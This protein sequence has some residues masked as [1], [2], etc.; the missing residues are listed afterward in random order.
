MAAESVLVVP[1]AV[2]TDLQIESG[3]VSDPAV[4]QAFLNATRTQ[5]SFMPREEAER[6]PD[7]VQPIPLAYIRHGRRLLV[8]PGD[9]RDPSDRLYRRWAVW[10]G[11]HIEQSDAEGGDP[12]QAGLR[13]ELVEEL[14]VVGLPPP[15]LVGL[16]GDAGS[17]RSRMHLGVVHRLQVDDPV[18]AAALERPEATGENG[19]ARTL[20]TDIDTLASSHVDMEPWS[21]F[22][23][24]D[25][26]RG[27][28]QRQN[29]VWQGCVRTPS[30]PCL[31]EPSSESSC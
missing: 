9:D 24:R 28:V 15:E 27:N 30:L 29:Q 2:V 17:V 23:I 14:N 31:W 10:V 20:L 11:G 22:I 12:I 3:F 13:R 4:V 8:L 1:R 18:L 7:Y 6:M 19:F 5:G 26:H 16:V 25:H 21:M